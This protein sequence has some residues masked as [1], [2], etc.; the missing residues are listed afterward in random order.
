MNIWDILK[1]ELEAF[2]QELQEKIRQ[3]EIER[4]EEVIQHERTLCII[5]ATDAFL[6]AKIPKERIIALLQKHW[7]LRRSEAEEALWKAENRV[8]RH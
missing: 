1:K 2:P 3:E 7:D 4:E 8:K 6:D 5:K